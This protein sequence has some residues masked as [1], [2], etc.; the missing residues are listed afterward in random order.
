MTNGSH[1]QRWR[2]NS[3]RLKVNRG[4]A[5]SSSGYFQ[6]IP[7]P[8]VNENAQERT[9]RR[10]RY[11][12]HFGWRRLTGTTSPA[13]TQDSVPRRGRRQRKSQPPPPPSPNIWNAHPRSAETVY[14]AWWRHSGNLLAPQNV[15]IELRR[16]AIN[17]QPLLTVINAHAVGGRR[18]LCERNCYVRQLIVALVK[19]GKWN[20]R[21]RTVAWLALEAL[22]F[23]IP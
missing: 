4:A 9:Y 1:R 8:M 15:S 18:L 22:V 2:L 20:R 12:W 3:G 6:A 10:Q 23:G 17:L 16:P 19:N 11:L 13:S 21:K 5:R 14:R 7:I